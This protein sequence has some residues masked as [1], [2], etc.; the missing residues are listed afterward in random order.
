MGE[1]R[2]CDASQSAARACLAAVRRDRDARRGEADV[3]RRDDL[4][5][6]RVDHR[7]FVG[8][9]GI[10]SLVRDVGILGNR[11]HWRKQPSQPQC[12]RRRNR[13]PPRNVSLRFHY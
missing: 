10:Y 9:I 6:S 2:Q 5:C 7:Y 3:D 8:E 4:V 12:C 13:S 1:R 11:G